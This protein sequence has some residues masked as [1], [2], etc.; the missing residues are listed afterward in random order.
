[1]SFPWH[2]PTVG[3][4][5]AWSRLR[6]RLFATHVIRAGLN[7]GKRIALRRPDPAFLDGSYE[8]P[9]QT[10]LAE[11]LAEGAVFY[12]VGANVGFFSLL[13]AS[14][15]G[16]SGAVYAFE[17]VP[18]N[19]ASIRHSARLNRLSN[20]EVF[21][22]AVGERSGSASLILSRHIGGA[23]LASKGAPQ[24]ATGE[25]EVAVTTL[26]DAIADR[27]LRP[28]SLIKIDVEGAELEVLRGMTD[29]LA[30]HRPPILY[31]ID[32]ATPEGLARKRREIASLLNAAGYRSIALPDAY[33][34][35]GWQVAHHLALPH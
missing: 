28:P 17:P 22:E 5:S 8:A 10:A 15:V 7:A 26:D 24:D 13:A 2:L 29:T 18:A 9:I 14:I 31:E 11:H 1:M 19:A 16:D 12:D 34:N 6:R 33:P 32:D 27:G 4:I 30:I 23:T 20:I 35:I 25:I 3:T 21:E